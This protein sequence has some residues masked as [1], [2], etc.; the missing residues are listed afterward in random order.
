MIKA[1]QQSLPGLPPP[2][3][4]PAGLENHS[5]DLKSLNLYLIGFV[6]FSVISVIV[7]VFMGLSRDTRMKLREQRIRKK[8][9]KTL[10]KEVLWASSAKV[11]YL[12]KSQGLDQNSLLLNDLDFISQVEKTRFQD[13]HS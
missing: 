13:K 10:G 11:F 8:L 9:S 12:V 4:N 3:I 1:N 2:W 5:I 7:Y 6:L